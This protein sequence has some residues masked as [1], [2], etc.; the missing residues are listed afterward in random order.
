MPEDGRWCSP[1]MITGFID[2]IS[3]S[4]STSSSSSSS[5][6]TSS[7]SSSSSSDNSSS[8]SSF[9]ITKPVALVSLTGT[10]RL[11]GS[12]LFGSDDDDGGGWS[13]VVVGDGE[14]LAILAQ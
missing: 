9:S 6:S 2:I 14:V 7:S 4:A 8:S 10:V 11:A 5:K 1:S 3:S 13:G 12:S